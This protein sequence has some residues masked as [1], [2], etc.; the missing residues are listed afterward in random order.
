MKLGCNTQG[1]KG[2]VDTRDCSQVT[3]DFWTS[4]G[5][6]SVYL[7]DTFSV[8][9]LDARFSVHS[10][11]LLIPNPDPAGSDILETEIEPG[12]RVPGWVGPRVG[13]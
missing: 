3:Y 4:L 1:R 5:G 13:N 10:N 8:Y 9:S 7:A 2:A 11:K 6:A 12:I